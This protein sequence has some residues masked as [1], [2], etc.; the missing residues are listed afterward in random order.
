MVILYT[1]V[2]VETDPA[3][4]VSLR[5]Q[6]GKAQRKA[7]NYLRRQQR[8]LKQTGPVPELSMSLGFILILAGVLCGPLC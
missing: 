3:H 5:K 4:H 6:R 1:V 2:A 8:E 7:F